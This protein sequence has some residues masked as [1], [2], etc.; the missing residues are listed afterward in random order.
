MPQVNKKLV[1]EMASNDTYE[2]I[3]VFFLCYPIHLFACL[4]QLF[5]SL[6]SFSVFFQPCS[7]PPLNLYSH[8]F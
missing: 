6:V 8:E 4:L 3:P 1:R 5:L 2:R 7:N